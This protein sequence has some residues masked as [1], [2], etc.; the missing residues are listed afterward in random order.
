MVVSSTDEQAQL[1][2]LM[3]IIP[4]DKLIPI[5]GKNIQTVAACLKKAKAYIGN[6]SGLMHASAA[7][8]VPTIGLFGPGFPEQYGP[9]GKNCAIVKTKESRE[10][11][12]K[13][14][15]EAKDGVPEKHLMHSIKPEDI[16]KAVMNILETSNE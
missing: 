6:D 11:L 2:P 16:F 14:L 9:Y 12:L 7:L 5:I 4:S 3:K 13:I 1:A 15:A 10:E 8:R